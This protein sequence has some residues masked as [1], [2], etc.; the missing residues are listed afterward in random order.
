MIATKLALNISSYIRLVTNI[1][2]VALKNNFVFALRIKMIKDH[3]ANLFLTIF[4]LILYKVFVCIPF[5]AKL[6]FD[7]YGLKADCWKQA[8]MQCAY[9]QVAIAVVKR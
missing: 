3:Y 7:Q 8:C 5:F 2:L 1:S 6:T 9:S 4:K